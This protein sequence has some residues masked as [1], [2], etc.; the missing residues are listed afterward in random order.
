MTDLKAN[1]FTF[2]GAGLT[3]MSCWCAWWFSG[4]YPEA[5]LPFGPAFLLVWAAVC[6]GTTLNWEI[7]LQQNFEAAEAGAKKQKQIAGQGKFKRVDDKELQEKAILYRLASWRG[8]GVFLLGRAAR[9]RR[10]A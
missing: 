9:R 2:G 1:G 4:G 5:L 8:R 7:M 10:G 3:L 6:A